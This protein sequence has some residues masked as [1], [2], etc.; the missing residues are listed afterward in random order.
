MGMGNK[1]DNIVFPLSQ[2]CYERARSAERVLEKSEYARPDPTRPDPMTLLKS[3]FLW[4][5]LADSRV[6]LFIVVYY[7]LSFISLKQP[8]TKGPLTAAVNG[9]Y[10]RTGAYSVHSYICT[11]IHT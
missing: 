11:F 3:L 6:V 1:W 9:T 10:I 8:Q 7:C 4:N 2:R 5:A